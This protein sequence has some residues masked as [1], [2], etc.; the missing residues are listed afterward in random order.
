MNIRGT[1]RVKFSNTGSPEYPWS[2]LQAPGSMQ[3]NVLKGSRDALLWV[4]VTG[5]MCNRTA[6]PPHF[7]GC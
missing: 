1:Q 5:P 6:P 4:G 3:D 2:S 7:A